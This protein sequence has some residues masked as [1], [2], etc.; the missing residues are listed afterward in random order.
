M[1]R[2]IIKEKIF[3]IKDSTEKAIVEFTQDNHSKS[4]KGVLAFAI[5][6]SA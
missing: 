1:A 6:R 2:K 3:N 4:T 5:H